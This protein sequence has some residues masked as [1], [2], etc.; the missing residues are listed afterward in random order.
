MAENYIVI[1]GKRAEL[2]EEQLKQ[3]GIEIPKANPFERV[4]CGPFYSINS[5]G[6]V[7][8]KH[9]ATWDT[10]TAL[11]N[12]ANYC[13]DKEMMEQR[14]LHETLNRILWRYS[15]EHDGDTIDWN[16]ADV[17]RFVI[18]YVHD[19]KQFVADGWYVY[20]QLGAVYFH[21]K[22]AAKAAIKE[23]VEPFMKAHPEFKW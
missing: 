14:A 4:K 23:I 17:C 10:D 2:T 7:D 12:V 21:T 1:N 19:D 20:Q 13:T 6:S 5:N 8:Q 16:N 18:N 22:E 3:L 9:D 15:I 11:F